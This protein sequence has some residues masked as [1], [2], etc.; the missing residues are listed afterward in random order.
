MS[1]LTRTIH[2]LHQLRHQQ[3][4]VQTSELDRLVVFAATHRPGDV[5][6]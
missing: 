2:Q 6:G 3:K 5:F 4:N 1:K